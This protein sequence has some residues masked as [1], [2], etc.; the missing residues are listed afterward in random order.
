MVTVEDTTPP[1]LS[2][3]DDIVDVEATGPDEPIETRAFRLT[4]EPNVP[5]EALVPQLL[6]LVE[7]TAFAQHTAL[8]LL[9]QLGA[10]HLEQVDGIAPQAFEAC[11]E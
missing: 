11:L 7:V 5:D 2:V 10:M 9:G 4:G 8:M 3:P 1:E 6:H